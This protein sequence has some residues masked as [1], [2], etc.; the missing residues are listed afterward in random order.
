L[1]DPYNRNIVSIRSFGACLALALAIPASAAAQSDPAVNAPPHLTDAG[2]L[3][4]LI[5]HKESGDD[6]ADVGKKFLVVAPSIGSK[7]ST[8]LNGGLSA[9]VAFYSGDPATTHISTINGGFKVSQ[10]GQLLTGVRINRFSNGDRW[11]F[12]G[13]NRFS[14]TSQN[15]YGLGGETLSTDVENVKY[16]YVR[17]FEGLYRHVAPG[18]FVGG[19]INVSDHSN[20]RPGAAS[21]NSW[22]ESAYI[23]YSAQ[24]GFDLDH[25]TSSGANVGI[26]YDTRDNAINAR[27]GW[28]AS[29][30][31][32]TYFDGFLGGDSTWQELYLD[33]RTYKKI[34]QD[35]RQRIA[36]WG[37]GDLVTGGVAPYLD[38]PAT[39]SNDGRS[40]R[41]YAEGRYRG[42]HLLYGEMEY[43]GTIT[44]SGLVGV[45]AFANVTT[46]DNSQT[47]DHLFQSAAP[48][49][50]FGFR[51]LLNKRS[52]TNLCTDYGWGEHGS[53]GF[54]LAIQEAF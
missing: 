33:V 12:Q 32:R 23:E 26:F 43:R 28:L 49:A 7:P 46:V 38:L 36:F 45:V 18:L 2:D 5:R 21:V 31:Y 53:R 9:N 42:E 22:D 6:D 48:A 30:S 14:L 1:A 25:Q 24:H 37:L 29:A 27:R 20:V 52:R 8:G 50:G 47:G 10:K 13:D 16:N 17:L 15:T 41:G 19:G 35:G 54:Y 51:F 40:A 39:A 11:F 4:R 44:K 3:W 34:S